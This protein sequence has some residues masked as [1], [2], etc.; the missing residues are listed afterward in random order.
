[1]AA[2]AALQLGR[3]LHLIPTLAD[4]RAQSLDEIAERLGTDRETVLD[5]IRALSVRYGDP[6]GFVQGVQIF[7]DQDR[8]LSLISNH[9][10][11]PMRLTLSELAALELGL[12]LLAVEH[13]PEERSVIE[14]A[15]GRIR[16]VIRKLPADWAPDRL[17]HAGMGDEDSVRHLPALR[18]A[19]S[20]RRRVRIAYRKAD[21]TK[22][23]SREVCPYA[24]T[25]ARGRWYLIGHC[26]ASDDVR[27]FRLDRIGTVEP[28]G[29]T[30]E[31][32][33]DFDPRPFTADGRVFHADQPVSLRVRYSARIAPWIAEREGKTPDADGTLTLD[34]PLADADWAVRHV[35]Q[36]G[37][38]AEVIEPATMRAALR[39]RLL[40]LSR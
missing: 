31:R 4:G 7:V 5:D 36:Y 33:D 19:R 25:Y 9:F 39:E 34:H 11:R 6:G 8:T 35:L 12:A 2:D 22:A 17:R 40:G 26:A 16:E 20:Q 1:M 30:F 10:A 32:P 24:I 3:L 37:P 18:K 23:E 21:A 14:R 38:D 28:L 29:A 13:S 27:V 15:R